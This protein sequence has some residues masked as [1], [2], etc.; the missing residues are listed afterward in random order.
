[1]R[2]S[3]APQ[4]A[5]TLAM[6]ST[7]AVAAWGF[8]IAP[9]TPWRWLF[10]GGILPV[11]WTY[12]KAAQMRGDDEEV[13]AA[14]MTFHR[15]VLAFAGFM[16]TARVGIRL[17][18]HGGFLDPSWLST[19]RRLG[20]LMMGVGMILFGNFLPTLRSPWSLAKQP[21]AWQQVHRFAGWTL[22]LGGIG[23]IGS[24]TFLPL[25]SADR[26]SVQIVVIVSLLVVGRKFASLTTH[27]VGPR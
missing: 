22:V 15:Y 5:L 17:A 27:A 14:L 11:V 3:H 20:A 25:D 24:W 21:F 6:A 12:V 7:A 19:G 23:V 13:G 10:L 26:A 16:L 9:D 4:M 2:R 1:M 18:V 8:W